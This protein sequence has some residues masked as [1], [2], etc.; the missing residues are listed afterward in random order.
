MS[1]QEGIDTSNHYGSFITQFMGVIAEFER[2]RIGERVK[3][4]R[5]FLIAQG[6]WPGG[7]TLYGYRWLA[8]KKQWAVIPEEAKIVRLIYD[9]YINRKMGIMAIAETLNKN[10]LFTRNGVPWLFSTLRAVLTNPGYKGRHKINIPMPVII[11]ENTWQLAQ[12][13]R[14]ESR[15]VLANPKGWLLQGICFC[16]KCGHMLKCLQKSYGTPRY[17]ACHYRVQYRATQDSSKRCN[18]PFVRA[19]WLEQAVWD[20]VKEILNNSDKM[21]ECVNKALV[22]LEERRKEIGAEN[23]SIESKLEVTRSK[24]ERLGIAFADGAV[25][26]TVYKSKLKRLNK[27]EEFL[28]K[29]QHSI[30]P[31][32]LGE[33]AYLGFCIEI[34]KD[35]LNKGSILITDL[36]II[37]TTGEDDGSTTRLTDLLLGSQDKSESPCEK[38]TSQEKQDSL[39]RNKRAILQ[40]FNI[41]VIVYPERVEVKEAIPIQLLEK[42]NKRESETAQIIISPSQTRQIMLP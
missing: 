24:K 30:D 40:M 12:Q 32:P 15:S 13:R 10:G 8:D 19:D 36:G 11:D 3:D 20:R 27:E 23:L 28:F 14:Q 26:L 25:D 22:D 1:I 2:G 42:T 4:S 7:R 38:T 16:G 35:I 39:L 18:L 41:K 37:V 17:Y 5:Q 34:V 9:L 6:I 31:A 29:S 21:T 33:I